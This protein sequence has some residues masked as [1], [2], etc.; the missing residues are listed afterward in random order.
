MVRVIKN[1][2]GFTLI[3]LMIVVAIISILA[4]LALPKFKK[5]QAKSMQAEART[6]LYYLFALEDTYR[7]D[8]GTYTAMAPTGNGYSNPS[9]PAS[10]CNRDND[11]GFRLESCDKVRYAYIVG[12]VTGSGSISDW[13]A[14][15]TTDTQFLA[16]ASTS[17]QS[18]F[19]GGDVYG[20]HNNKVFPG[21]DVPDNWV[22]DQAKNLRNV[23]VGAYDDM[24]GEPTNSGLAINA[25]L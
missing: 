2:L 5:F 13:S 4:S 16:T 18:I 23:A 15:G 20:S 25:C 9:N 8:H 1:Q 6:N 19:T 22:I 7:L 11:L 17:D 12:T 24:T 3:E 14:T 10:K 21:C